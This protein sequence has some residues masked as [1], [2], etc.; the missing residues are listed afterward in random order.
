MSS[1]HANPARAAL[2]LCTIAV[3]SLSMS[4]CATGGMGRM[5]PEMIEAESAMH[6]FTMAVHMGEIEEAQLAVSKATNAQVRDFAQRMIT[7]HT[8]GMQREHQMMMQMGM[9]MEM[10]MGAN[11]QMD[12]ARMRTMLMEHP[13][14]RPV[15][16]DH[17]RAMQMLQG[18]SG[19]AFDQAYMSRQVTMHRYA[20]EQVDRMMTTMG[21]APAAGGAGQGGAGMTGGNMNMDVPATRE[22][23][24]MMH[25][26]V[27][28]MLASH[29]EMAQQIMNATGS[30]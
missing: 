24:M 6:H 3:A 8:A 11:G 25:R 14:S 12:M 23:R 26:N 13:H 1:I 30:R 4:A 16:E 29:L 27:R 9:G 10:E 22:G 19:M 7:E 15:V 2:R 17:M 21:M 28:A 5:S 20:L 18:V